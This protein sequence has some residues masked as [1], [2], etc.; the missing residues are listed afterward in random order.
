MTTSMSRWLVLPGMSTDPSVAGLPG[1]SSDSPFSE[2]WRTIGSFTPTISV[3]SG[4]T[5][6]SSTED[7][8]MALSP[9]FVR[10][11]S[12]FMPMSI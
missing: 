1:A 2:A 3:Y 9:I 11:T 7:F 8:S 12:K 6:E 5:L 4:A 10:V